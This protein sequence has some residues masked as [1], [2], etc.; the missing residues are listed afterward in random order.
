M[1]NYKPLLDLFFFFFS[2]CSK[3]KLSW[4]GGG[5]WWVAEGAVFNAMRSICS[6]GPWR[7]PPARG[8]GPQRGTSTPRSPSQSRT[9]QSE[10]G[11]PGTQ[12]KRSST[13]RGL[14][15]P[16]TASGAG[17][18]RRICKSSSWPWI[19]RFILEGWP[20][21]SLSNSVES[22]GLVIKSWTKDL[23]QTCCH[24]FRLELVCINKTIAA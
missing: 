10:P 17:D 2:G 18:L 13:P 22:L 1:T 16:S 11:T 23:W 7:G 21:P 14:P 3:A 4:C 9:S 15:A 24:L 12:S 5:S 20:K 19:K 8:R 6:Q